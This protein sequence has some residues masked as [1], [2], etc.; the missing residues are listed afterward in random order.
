MTWHLLT[1]GVTPGHLQVTQ[2]RARDSRQR[3]QEVSPLLSGCLHYRSLSD[4]AW[5]S[6]LQHYYDA[7]RETDVPAVPTYLVSGEVP[8]LMVRPH[9]ETQQ[10][11][12]TM[13]IDLEFEEDREEM[14]VV[15]QSKVLLVDARTLNGVYPVHTVR[16][17]LIPTLCL[18]ARSQFS[19]IHSVHI[20]SLSPSRL[21][22]RA[23]VLSIHF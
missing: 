1:Y 6:E 19:R 5:K 13:D 12:S 9:S 20:Y 3:C 8:A 21:G 15:H 16:F 2:P 17:R 18:D 23:C 7:V 4:P 14:D 22:V 11:D 10:S